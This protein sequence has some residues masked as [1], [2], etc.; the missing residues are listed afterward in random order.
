[1]L[2][3][4]FDSDLP[5]DLL[6]ARL[7]QHWAVFCGMSRHP[8]GTTVVH[9]TSEAVPADFKTVESQL[10]SALVATA[11]RPTV[12]VYGAAARIV[13]ADALIA[14]DKAI[15]YVV[16]WN[17]QHGSSAEAPVIDGRVELEFVAPVAGLYRIRIQRISELHTGY[18]MIKAAD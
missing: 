17:G 9:F 18:V 2:T 14:A 3:Q 7:R 5:L 4:V 10:K 6:D 13:C 15:Q 8:D 12:N 16:D 11:D 1:M